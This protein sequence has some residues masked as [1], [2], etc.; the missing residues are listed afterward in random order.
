MTN[1]I[2][3]PALSKRFNLPQL[4]ILDESRNQFGTWKDRKAKL[5]IQ[6]ALNHN[7]TT[8]CAITA[9][10]TGLSLAGFASDCN[11]KVVSVVNQG[12]DQNTTSLLRAA[13]SQVVSLDL[14]NKFYGPE[15]LISIID[16][17]S[18]GNILDAS[19]GYAHSYTSIVEDVLHLNPDFIVAPIGSGEAFLGILRGITQYNLQSKLIG[20]APSTATSIA[21]KLTLFYSPYK[22]LLHS[23]TKTRAKIFTVS[24]HEILDSYKTIKRFLS[25]EPSSSIVWATLPRLAV[26]PTDVVVMINSGRGHFSEK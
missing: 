24:E 16:K 26:S 4:F 20:V 7:I 5:V 1:I 13:G 10:N 19:N 23:T 17:T 2:T 25:C 14:K 22:T 21:D 15:E 9:G 11:I 8:V 12:A 18:S 6:D 3:I